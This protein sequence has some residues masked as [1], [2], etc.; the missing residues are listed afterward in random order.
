MEDWKHLS[1]SANVIFNFFEGCSS[2]I[3]AHLAW[4]DSETPLSTDISPASLRAHF[5]EL[6]SVA[7]RPY[8]DIALWYY[9]RH[10]GA[11]M[12]GTP[13]PQQYIGIVCKSVDAISKSVTVSNECCFLRVNCNGVRRGGLR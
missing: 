2:K 4:N 13:M 5:Y 1:D 11:P 6:L 7:L 3:P 8:V 9:R 10:L 12:S